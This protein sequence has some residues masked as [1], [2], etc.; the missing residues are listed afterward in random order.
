[1][2]CC[3][4]GRMLLWLL[5][6]KWSASE[7]MLAHRREGLQRRLSAS[8]RSGY[9]LLQADKLYASLRSWP[10]RFCTIR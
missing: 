8:L 5:D 9:E 2:G 6:G 4:M 3:C 7:A 10:M 1:M